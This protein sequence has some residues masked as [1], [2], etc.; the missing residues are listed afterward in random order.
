[1]LFDEVV[2]RGVSLN[3]RDGPEL[4]AEAVDD[5]VAWFVGDEFV[6]DEFVAAEFVTAEFAAGSVDGVTSGTVAAVEEF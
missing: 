3:S 1:V 6:S 4:E 2:F 5:G